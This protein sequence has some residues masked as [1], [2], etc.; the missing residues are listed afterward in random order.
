MNEEDWNH[1][2]TLSTF[3]DNPEEVHAGF[4]G[5]CQ[6]VQRKK[7]YRFDELVHVSEFPPDVVAHLK[8]EYTYYYVMFWLPRI[9][10][11]TVVLSLTMDI[12]V[13]IACQILMNVVETW[14][15]SWSSLV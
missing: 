6:T 4:I 15:A 12:W 3:M 11:L 9:I 8:R 7:P 10:A 13:P 1:Y 5:L 14:A 2:R